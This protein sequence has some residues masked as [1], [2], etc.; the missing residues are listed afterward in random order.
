MERK[1]LVLLM[2]LILLTSVAC[3]EDLLK[4]LID[5]FF[6]AIKGLI[7]IIAAIIFGLFP[8]LKE[9]LSADILAPVAKDWPWIRGFYWLV[10]LAAFL[11]VIAILAKLWSMGEHFVINTIVGLLLLLVLI[12]IFGVEIQI[13]LLVLIL[14]AIFGVPGVIFV[15]ILHYL[16]IP[17]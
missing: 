7:D 10:Y 6:G 13:T 15:L 4:P 1:I 3:A 9:S 2:G 8:G 14:T 12:H 11:A 17:L 5:T 16:G